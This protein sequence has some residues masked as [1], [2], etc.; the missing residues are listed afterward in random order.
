MKYKAVIFD[1]FGTLVDISSW[2]ESNDILRQMATVLL[3][4]SDNFVTSWHATFDER[5]TGIFE[6]YQACIRHIC[7]QLGVDVQDNQIEL[8]A[9]IRFGMTK[10]EV[11]SLRD[12]AKEVLLHLKANGY[13]TGL[14]SD[15]SKET[16]IILRDAPLYSLIDVAVFSCSVGVRKPDPR[17]YRIAV[18]G[19]SVNPEECIYIADGMGQEL[20]KASE[21][22]MYAIQICVPGKDDHNYDPYRENWDGPQISS[23]TEV[24]SLLG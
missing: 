1:L 19:L 21:L 20:T 11:K 4:P 8:A 6:S 14:I 7:R 12:G 3:V 24:I 10:Q 22:G 16:T 23:L 15:C 2:I 17:I 18:E 9:S 13:K 5:M